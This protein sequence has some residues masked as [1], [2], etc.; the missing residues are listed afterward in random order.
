MREH[1]AALATLK[2]A[3]KRRP[4]HQGAHA[5]M[6][7]LYGVMGNLD[8]AIDSLENLS[9]LLPMEATIF[10]NLGRV[11]SIRGDREKVLVALRKA[12][13]LSPEYVAPRYELAKIYSKDDAWVDSLIGTLAEIV[14]IEPK[15]AEAHYNLGT[16]YYR[17]G[18]FAEA[19]ESLTRAI[20]LDSA[21]SNW[22]FALGLALFEGG[23]YAEA[24]TALARETS[25]EEEHALAQYMLGAAYAAI[26][27]MELCLSALR[28][29]ARID[30]KIEGLIHKDIRFQQFRTTVQYEQFLRK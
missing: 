9:A 11:Y 28:K 22:N 7:E 18:Q 30:P 21:H 2:E 27:D 8:G 26:G 24:V 12:I 15:N 13:E 19:I 14:R 4:E 16:T 25:I 23:K 29:A 6:A 20:E 10:Y 5:R 3:V 1:E 17:K